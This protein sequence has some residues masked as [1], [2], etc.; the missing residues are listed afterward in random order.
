[1]LIP[2]SVPVSIPVLSLEDR[3]QAFMTI[4]PLL[5]TKARFAFRDLES[6]HD[7]DDAV[8]E[9]VALAWEHFRHSRSLPAS[10]FI[11]QI[12]LF[13]A[14]VRQQLSVRPV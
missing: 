14:T 3:Q 4:L 5:E 12:P 6:R 11:K 7:R 2:M 10:L 13:I 9:V 8:A 1:M